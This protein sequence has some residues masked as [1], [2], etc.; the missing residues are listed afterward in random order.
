[1]IRFA[2]ILIL[3]SFCFLAEAADLS[4][5]TNQEAASGLKSAL[6]QGT[7]YA[8]THLGR[9]DGFLGNPKVKI[10]LPDNLKKGEKLLK[11]LGMSKYTD[12][13]TVA[14]NRAAE[15]AVAE[16]KPILA[17][18]VKKMTVQDAKAILTGGDDSVTQFFRRSTSSQLTQ[19]FK[20]IVHRATSKV[21]LAEKYNQFA[22]KA[23]GLIGS[24]DTDLD[25]YV[26][27][28]AMDGLFLMIA[29]QERSLRQNPLGAGNTLLSKV[30]GA[31]R[32]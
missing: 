15:Q 24:Q 12:E 17:D 2:Q 30:F 11:T 25:S 28:K 9:P 6:S 1:M 21:K 13:L 18:A 8:V 14:M 22:G 7:E 16:A 5:I 27:R 19:K 29:E 4:G 20:P 26:T 32:H 3:A 23:S 10:G 31:L